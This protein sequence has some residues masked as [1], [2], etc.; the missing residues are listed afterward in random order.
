MTAS[1]SNRILIGLIATAHGIRGLVK[2][3]LYGDDPDLLHET[4]LFTS[5]TG[6][7]TTR[8]SMK[9]SAGKYWLAE[10]DGITDRT[11]AEKLRGTQ[12]WA[13][14][15]EMP[16]AKKGSYYY[17]DLIGLAAFAVD[18]TPAGKVIDVQ[19]FGAGDLL[20]IQ[21]PGG[22]SYYMRFS[23]ETVPA[24]DIKAGKITIVPPDD[25][26]E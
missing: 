8:L 6:H 7:E 18:G 23:K 26:T 1:P 24:V 15:G 11:A 17:G 21:P 14:R 12:L 19:N 10:I 20:E 9:S 13:E 25:E 4:D 2:V 3:K 5:E 16:E 22:E